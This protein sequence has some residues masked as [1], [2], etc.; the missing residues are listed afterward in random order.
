MC[1]MRE[2]IKSSTFV[3]ALLLM[4]AAVPAARAQAGGFEIGVGIGA[5]EF[6]DNLGGENELRV[7]VRG[8]YF[9]TDRFELE[10]QLIR[11]TSIFD[12]TLTAYM[13]NGVFRLGSSE[14][15]VPYLLVGA[16]TANVELS[17]GPF[18][19]S[20]DDDGTA[21]QVGLG[22]RFYFG[23]S[24]RGSFRLEL[25][26]LNED[27]FDQDSTSFSLTGGVSWRFGA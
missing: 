6:D 18:G 11:A 14:R 3:L 21:L 10:G 19:V 1:T 25:S 9:F 24:G 12:L 4:L 20:V 16:G 5:M 2:T 27:S 13:V 17:G 8:G 15:V 22:T 23:D 26:A 7:D